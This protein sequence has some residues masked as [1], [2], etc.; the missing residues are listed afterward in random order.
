MLRSDQLTTGGTVR[1][2]LGS[3]RRGEDRHQCVGSRRD[4]HMLWHVGSQQGALTGLHRALARVRKGEGLRTRE[5]AVERLERREVGYT[6]DT[7][8]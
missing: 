4:L 5:P 6:S 2:R 7:S 3:F 1:S 8:R